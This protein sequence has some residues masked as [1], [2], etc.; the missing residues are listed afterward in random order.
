MDQRFHIA[1]DLKSVHPSD[2]GD[3]VLA[4]LA[5]IASILDNLLVL[6]ST[7][8]FDSCEHGDSPLKDTPNIIY[9]FLLYNKYLKS[10]WHYGFANSCDF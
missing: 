3:N 4:G 6:V 8:F 7:G 1:F 2:S 10:L 5:V 9:I